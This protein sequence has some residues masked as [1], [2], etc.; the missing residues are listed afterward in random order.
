MRRPNRG[1]GRRLDRRL[2]RRLER[3]DQRS[4]RRH[5]TRGSVSIYF[6]SLTS[7]FVLLSALLIDFSR[8]AAF[9][10][11]AELAVQAGVRSVLS[12]YD[13]VVFERYGLFIR[14]GEDGGM[15]LRE[16]LEGNGI[17]SGGTGPSTSPSS[18]FAYLDM[19]WSEAEVTESRPLADHEVFRRQVL[20][21]M[22]YKAP[23][24]LTLELAERF[25]GMDSAIR[26]AAD[27][28][29]VLERM[30]KAYDRREAALDRALERQ[31]QAGE[32]ATRALR[33]L[34]PYPS[35]P[36]NGS[37]SAGSFSHLA[38]AAMRY[39][40][41]VAKRLA[42]DA[43]ER[44]YWEAVAAG[45]QVLPI[46]IRPNAAVVAA[47]AS[48][49]ASLATRLSGAA[50]RLRQEVEAALAAAEQSL[51]QA[52]AANVEMRLIARQAAAAS[53]GGSGP[54]QVGP[55]AGSGS[56]NPDAGSAS[57]LGNAADSLAEIRKTAAEMVLSEAFFDAYAA[58]LQ[59]QKDR[60]D[61]LAQSA[62][63]GSSPLAAV[64]GM[65]TTSGELRAAAIR[66]ADALSDYAGS[67]GQDGEAIRNRR[68]AFEQHRS[69]DAQ[70]KALEQEARSEWTGWTSLLGGFRQARGTPEDE[71]AF[72]KAAGLARDNLTWNEKRDEP[73]NG[74]TMEGADPSSGRDAAMAGSTDALG[75]LT[76]ALTGARDT[77]YLA[78]Y[79]HARFS[80]FPPAQVKQLLEGKS[81]PLSLERQQAEYALYGFASPTGN[82][83]AAYGEIFALRLAIRT[84]EGLIV[85]RN[86][87]HPLLVLAAALV[88]GVRYAVQ[89]MQALLARDAVPLSKYVKANTSY[90]DY[91]RLF[92]L[93]HGS[94][95]SAISR[96]IAVF[97][98]A[99]GLDAT[100]TYTYA[101]AEGTATLKLWFFPGLLQLLHRAGGLGGTLKG[102]RYEATY[103]AEMG[104]Q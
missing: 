42:D 87:G 91:L 11:Q 4:E 71:A 44:A 1:R 27:T 21:E 63:A 14:G 79:V 56:A 55:S 22:K 85:S 30:R 92:M 73:P 13:P 103:A 74:M 72:R 18:E 59:A 51:R 8:I 36:V 81:V 80:R 84:L 76:G 61:R 24:D 5:S 7:A 38:D 66:L 82:L 69:Q 95:A 19:A 96:C 43:S 93:L 100:Q 50:N 58:E 34:T 20:E 83:A 17:G 77:L 28:V 65:G 16:T 89:D 29:D 45:A 99:S 52:V 86:A 35:V 88:Y 39:D 94:S 46:N 78:E 97:E 10:K 2:D 31:T 23:I 102:N 40:D 53:T 47:Y 6:I 60:T 70:R 3:S 9:R 32:Q 26:D 57:D 49:A 98:S 62:G 33:D 15:L 75:A 90:E 41:Y 12:S 48:S 104:Y 67:Y 37:R 68:A 101:R 54:A 25:K 64:S